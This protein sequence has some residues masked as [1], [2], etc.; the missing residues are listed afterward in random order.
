ME[1]R[2]FY[3]YGKVRKDTRIEQMSMLE[4]GLR[5]YGV[6]TYSEDQ[7]YFDFDG[8][9]IIKDLIQPQ[10]EYVLRLLWNH[11]VS[12]IELGESDAIGEEDT[13]YVIYMQNKDEVPSLSG[14]LR[15]FEDY[16]DGV[17]CK[18]IPDTD[19]DNDDDDGE[20]EDDIGEDEE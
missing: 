4:Q 20:E 2:K 8:N 18:N 19:G 14:I 13:E 5:K 3:I 10:S 11:C 7:Y 12:I 1:S 15:T 17:L 6:D 9:I 16:L